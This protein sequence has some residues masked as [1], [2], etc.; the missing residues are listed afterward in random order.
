[1]DWRDDA[2]C[3]HT[4]P[5]LFFRPGTTGLAVSQMERAKRICQACPVRTPCLSWGL[6]QRSSLG[7]WGGTTEDE[8]RVIR[9]VAIPHPRSPSEPRSGK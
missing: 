9:G 1:M 5:D 2:A 4:D 7:I 8:R 3:G 6:D